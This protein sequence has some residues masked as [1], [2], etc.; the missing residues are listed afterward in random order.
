MTNKIY[1]GLTLD[2][3]I[4][5]KCK[6]L[7]IQDERS[8]SYYVN[9][10][11]KQELLRMGEMFERGP[12]KK[13]DT[14]PYKFW[15]LFEPDA[16]NAKQYIK[17]AKKIVKETF[18][19]FVSKDHI[20]DQHPFNERDQLMEGQGDIIDFMD[21]MTFWR[22]K[23]KGEQIYIIEYYGAIFIFRHIDDLRKGDI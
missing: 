10:V 7:A 16:E 5:A 22:K 12:I 14:H 1:A 6:E 2:K 3:E 9:N 19:K 21:G 11:L 4:V 17:D 8:F 18:L 20:G 15:K 13:E 23:F